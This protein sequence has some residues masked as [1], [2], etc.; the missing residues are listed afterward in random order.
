[1]GLSAE[2]ALNALIREHLLN[3]ATLQRE[4]ATMQ[5]NSFAERLLRIIVAEP[6]VRKVIL[7][8]EL[9]GISEAMIIRES[10]RIIKELQIAADNPISTLIGMLTGDLTNQAFR[11]AA[12]LGLPD[13]QDI[14][15]KEVRGLYILFRLGEIIAEDAGEKRSD[16][17]R[18]VEQL[19]KSPR[20]ASSPARDINEKGDGSIFPSASS[21]AQADDAVRWLNL[22]KYLLY[23]VGSQHTQTVY[24][25]WRD[26]KLPCKFSNYI[27]HGFVLPLHNLEESLTATKQKGKKANV[28]VARRQANLLKE[29]KNSF[30]ATVKEF[31]THI[32]MAVEP[33][34]KGTSDDPLPWAGQFNYFAWSIARDRDGHQ[35]IAIMRRLV[36]EM[37]NALVKL[38][39]I[40]HSSASSPADI[41]PAR[42]IAT[43]HFTMHAR[44][45]GTISQFIRFAGLSEREDLAIFFSPLE[46]G[47]VL[48][49]DP[50]TAFELVARNRYLVEGRAV[51]ITVQCDA[52]SREQNQLI[53][54]FVADVFSNYYEDS[55]GYITQEARKALNSILLE[56]KSAFKNW[57]IGD[58]SIFPSAS[59]P[60]G[61]VRNCLRQRLLPE[62]V[63][64]VSPKEHLSRE[65]VMSLYKTGL[66]AKPYLRLFAAVKALVNPENRDFRLLVGYSG[67]SIC[68]AMLMFNPSEVF[69]VDKR[70][71][72]TY[73]SLLGNLFQERKRRETLTALR[74][75]RSETF[76]YGSRSSYASGFLEGDSLLE[77]LV[78]MRVKFN[79]VQRGTRGLR[80]N[81]GYGDHLGRDREVS[82]FTEVDLHKP[83]TYPD[84]L[85]AV[86]ERGIDGYLARATFN[87]PAMFSTYLPI[88][89]EAVRGG[90]YLVLDTIDCDG[91]YHD[92]QQ[93]LNPEIW[94]CI[95]DDN[96]V[97]QRNAVKAYRE[98]VAQR[99]YWHGDA[100]MRNRVLSNYGCNLYVYHKRADV[101]KG[102]GS[103][104][105]GSVSS[106]V[107][108]DANPPTSALTVSRSF[109]IVDPD[110]IH[111][112]PAT[113][114]CEFAR[115]IN[116]RFGIEIMIQKEGE[117]EAV[118]AQSVIDMLCLNM[119]CGT[120]LTI[121][122]RGFCN[123]DK[124]EKIADLAQELF[125]AKRY[126]RTPRGFTPINGIEVEVGRLMR[127]V[128]V[129]ISSSPAQATRFAT[130]DLMNGLKSLRNMIALGL[131]RFQEEARVKPFLVV[132]CGR[133][134]TS[135]SFITRLMGCFCFGLG[136]NAL[137]VFEHDEGCSRV[138]YNYLAIPEARALFFPDVRLAIVEGYRTVPLWAV[139]QGADLVV[140]FVARDEVR[141]ERLIQRG[142]SPAHT[143]RL[144]NAPRLACDRIQLVIDTS[145]V[146]DLES[147]RRLLSS[148]EGVGASS[149]AQEIAVGAT[150][151][152]RLAVFQ[153]VPEIDLFDPRFVNR[154]MPLGGHPLLWNIGRPSIG[155]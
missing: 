53:A 92:P 103:H 131:H 31:V 36:A 124:L 147:A 51:S 47:V 129:T 123:Q 48:F 116:K 108:D 20:G 141:W 55:D 127:E 60:A 23:S 7:A 11:V 106:P 97:E 46:D 58:G 10:I 18:L 62:T 71:E 35:K 133:P 101:N 105:T 76:L 21:P 25:V 19:R 113:R 26:F 17:E 78:A 65:P 72:F 15:S 104:F 126:T 67:P 57:D 45:A 3:S 111:S 134:A 28:K 42:A 122:I 100:D 140:E 73:S 144:F 66:Y 4:L 68:D 70:R 135:K 30:V 102:G 80:F 14:F 77:D 22:F 118:S 43:L 1:F 56:F 81:W 27:E 39:E 136:E 84:C 96:L 63:K 52:F 64:G 69:N 44:P 130:K 98:D 50:L 24:C 120:R 137:K 32:D 37:E 142:W 16:R 139:S 149:P 146:L 115:A 155:I 5:P 89:A 121:H 2:E 128:D 54:Q 8:L 85:N 29:I 94:A 13:K 148:L 12:V 143:L 154:D 153:A 110:G 99:P 114:M 152:G 40:I 61:Q 119:A 6:E 59:S 138:L 132:I 88:I 82:W 109:E 34:N 93:V 86:L 112:W 151:A 49:T 75:R 87:G 125:L 145:N 150:V 41:E 117:E 74:K 91:K 83:N 33:S 79:T 107:E 38:E 9:S 90:G 95:A